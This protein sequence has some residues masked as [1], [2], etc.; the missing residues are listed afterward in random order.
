MTGT[1]G[2]ATDPLVVGS[3]SVKN[4]PAGGALSPTGGKEATIKRG[5]TPNAAAKAAATEA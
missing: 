3:R 4:E 5:C 2:A 1:L